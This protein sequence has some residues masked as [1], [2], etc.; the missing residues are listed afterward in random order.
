MEGSRLAE[1]I[2][3]SLE[4]ELPPVALT[5]VDRVPDGVPSPPREVPSA[6][7][8]WRDAE[9]GTFFASAAAHH[10]CAVGAM[11][12]G[13]SLPTEVTQRLGELVT[14]MCEHGYLDE[15]E[16]SSIPAVDHQSAGIVYG[17]LAETSNVP[18]VV[19]FWVTPRQ[20]MLC[21]EAVGAAHWTTPA[22]GL[23][24]RPGC[25]ALPVAMADSSP[26]LSLGCAGLRTFTGIA[27]DR[28][29]LAVPGGELE[30]F[31]DAIEKLTAA[32][33]HMLDFYQGQ[34]E[35]FPTGTGAT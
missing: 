24:G 32:N 30:S 10:N 22:P 23:T 4:L 31:A 19:L 14:G 5:F 13:F 6:C 21:N 18:S 15:N 29:L 26:T 20:A 35:K 1:R 16:A 9:Q 11:V 25:A 12:M 27:E 3:D 8:F 33:A 7:S 28:M 34:R 2:V 17:T